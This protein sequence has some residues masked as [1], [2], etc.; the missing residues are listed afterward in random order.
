M[1]F[2]KLTW[3]CHVCK[4]ERPDAKIS[5]LTR[6]IDNIPDSEM[7][8]RYCNDNPDCVERVKTIKLSE[9]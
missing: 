1:D 8:I 5:V 7:N 2:S 3:K 4:K 9:M 6:P